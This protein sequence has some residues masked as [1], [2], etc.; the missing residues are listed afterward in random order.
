MHRTSAVLHCSRAC[1]LV[2]T[3]QC[4]F[5]CCGVMRNYGA[6]AV[7]VARVPCLLDAGVRDGRLT[8]AACHDA[9]V[10]FF[11]SFLFFLCAALPIQ[12]S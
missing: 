2:A 11:S 1:A 10:F 12:Q 3:P 4:N 5:L 7:T 9:K 6:L 8:Y